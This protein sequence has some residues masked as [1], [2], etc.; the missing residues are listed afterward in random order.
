M[1]DSATRLARWA[2]PD[3][4]HRANAWQSPYSYANDSPIMANDPRG[5]IPPQVIAFV[6]GLLTDA[7]TQ[8]SE[9]YIVNDKTFVQSLDAINWWWSIYEGGVSA[10]NPAGTVKNLVKVVSSP[11]VRKVVEEVI[12][13]SIDLIQSAVN[14]Y[15]KEGQIDVKDLIMESLLGPAFRKG[16]KLIPKINT[17]KL[18]RKLDVVENQ[19]DRQRRITS[20]SSSARRKNK[21]ADLEA[22]QR[23]IKVEVEANQNAAQTLT[24][25]VAKGATKQ[26]IKATDPSNSIPSALPSGVPIE[27]AIEGF[28]GWKQIGASCDG[29]HVYSV[30]YDKG[31]VV[32]RRTEVTV[33]F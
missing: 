25:K 31:D 24:G 2:T 32:K 13:I 20:P 28:T 5:D 3:P 10:V 19:L 33:S 8:F 16:E 22:Q 4:K 9:Q 6:A 17:P 30:K 7:L 27:T 29:T 21:L 11:A 26:I 14:S 15:Y 23:K 18:D 1:I 12:D